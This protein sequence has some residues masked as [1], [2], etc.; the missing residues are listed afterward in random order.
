[1]FANDTNNCT[2]F[3][4]Y[5]YNL[6]FKLYRFDSFDKFEIKKKKRKKK[7]EKQVTL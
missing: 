2:Y 1:M 5:I 7:V 4:I 6:N 3:L